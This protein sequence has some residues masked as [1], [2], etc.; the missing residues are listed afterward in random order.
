MRPWLCIAQHRAK[1]ASPM[2]FLCCLVT[3][4]LNLIR[5]QT[6]ISVKFAEFGDA[7]S[8]DIVDNL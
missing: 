6:Q 8:S 3:K 1:P 7:L 2:C 4:H 5:P